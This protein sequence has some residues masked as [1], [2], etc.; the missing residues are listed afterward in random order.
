VFDDLTEKE[1]IQ[2]IAAWRE[3]ARRIAHEVKNPLTPIQ[4]SAQRLRRRYL[5]KLGP[6]EGEVLDR[7]TKTIEK[8]VEELRRLVNEFSSFARMPASRPA[9]HDLVQVVEEVLSLYSEAHRE[10][11]FNLKAPSRPPVFL[12]D[13]DQIKRAL[14][15]LL[16][17]AV[18]SMPQ[19]G[20]IQVEIVTESDWVRLV[21]ADTGPGV[22]PEDKARLFEPYFSRKKGGT[23]LGLAIVNSIV[24]E[25]NGKVWVEDNLPRGARFVIELP[26]RGE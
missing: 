7:C 26:L 10:F 24:T 13:R 17:N 19:G 20:E 3:V 4:L 14:I 16:D 1:K 6:E 23:G 5:Q 15:N 25:H 18:A 2:R 9:L 21:V 12:F 11:S 8:Q 22:S